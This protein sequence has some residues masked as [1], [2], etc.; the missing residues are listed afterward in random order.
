MFT[1]IIEEIGIVKGFEKSTIGAMIT[2]ACKDVLDGTKI[3]DSIA[4]NGVCQTVV[5]MDSES[6]TADVSNETLK[7]TNFLK[8]KKGSEVNL[9][10]ALSMNSRFGG[11]I[12][13]GHIDGTAVIKTIEKW[14]SFYDLKLQVESGL[15]KYI[16]RK[17]SITVNGVSLTIADS[18][19]RDF[20]IAIIP[21]TFE[22]T[23][24]RQ[25]KIGDIVNIETDVL[26]KYIEKI[27]SVN[28]NTSELSEK[29]LKENGFD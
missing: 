7:V 3:G 24:L 6:F 14:S 8:L 17:G 16:V 19:K 9:E 22:N 11:H 12:V 26:A 5:K 13:N 10:R 15:E 2:V 1:G 23:N 20:T 29:F 18:Y 4:I 21:H 25:L 27:L 28:D